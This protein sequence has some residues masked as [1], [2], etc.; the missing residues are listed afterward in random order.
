MTVFGGPLLFCF[1]P[2]IPGSFELFIE[3]QAF[4]PSEN[5]APPPPPLPPS[6]VSKL[7]RG[8]TGNLRNRDNLLTE[9]GR[10]GAGVGDKIIR[11]RE[12]LPLYKL[13]NNLSLTSDFCR[14]VLFTYCHFLLTQGRIYKH[15]MEK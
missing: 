10:G 12:S 7:D 13:F 8:H 6:P 14:I 5:L 1:G 11:Q 4:S 2:C 15:N 9:E 3:D